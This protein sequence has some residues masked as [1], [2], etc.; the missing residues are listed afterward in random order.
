MFPVCSY[1]SLLDGLERPSVFIVSDI[2]YNRIEVFGAK[3]E[4]QIRRSSEGSVAKTR[5]RMRLSTELRI[6]IIRGVITSEEQVPTLAE[7]E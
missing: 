2:N 7:C 3:G 1:E 4:Q 5:I 6:D